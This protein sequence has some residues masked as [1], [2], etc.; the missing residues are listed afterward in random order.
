M[1]EDGFGSQLFVEGIL[2]LERVEHNGHLKEAV[3]L[4]IEEMRRKTVDNG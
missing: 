3:A 4:V 1:K 2:Q